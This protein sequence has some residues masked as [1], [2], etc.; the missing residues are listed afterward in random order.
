[1]NNPELFQCSFHWKE[2]AEKKSSWIDYIKT[3]WIP[4]KKLKK[5]LKIFWQ[6]KQIHC[7]AQTHKGGWICSFCEWRKEFQIIPLC[8]WMLSTYC[9]W[10]T[11][12]VFRIKVVRL[13]RFYC[14][15]CLPNPLHCLY[16]MLMYSFHSTSSSMR[17]M[18][19]M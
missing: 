8:I 4:L 19:G 5:R 12:N 14:L 10:F 6:Q 9:C 2:K 15:D 1:M 17:I 11:R 13:D 18:Y 7:L 16:T 3:D